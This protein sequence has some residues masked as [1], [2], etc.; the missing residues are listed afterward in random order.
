MAC[1]VGMELEQRF[2]TMLA[3][4]RGYTLSDSTLSLRGDSSVH[5]RFVAR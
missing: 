5:A 3:A 1:E 2:L 4:T